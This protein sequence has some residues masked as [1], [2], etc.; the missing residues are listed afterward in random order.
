MS[1]M[2]G[3]FTVYVNTGLCRREI[4]GEEFWAEDYYD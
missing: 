3:A 1:T 2:T 4:T